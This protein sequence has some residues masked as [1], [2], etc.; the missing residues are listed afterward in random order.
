MLRISR[1][2]ELLLPKDVAETDVIT[3]DFAESLGEDEVILGAT[4]DVSVAKGL[5]ATPMSIRSGSA[6]VATPVVLQQVVGGVRNTE[7]L[8]VCA[9][10]TDSGRI[11][12][13]AGLLPVV[14]LGQ[15]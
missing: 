3:F 14:S 10:T 13:V 1:S 7:Y 8:L 11:L 9:A 15:P 12:V 2:P 6:Q 4:V 5:D